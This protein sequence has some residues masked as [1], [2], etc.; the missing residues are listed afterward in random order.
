M[1]SVGT[2]AAVGKAVSISGR[3]A[4][5]GQQQSPS[6]YSTLQDTGLHTY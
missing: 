4:F 2:T 3:D 6:D 5:A 1:Y